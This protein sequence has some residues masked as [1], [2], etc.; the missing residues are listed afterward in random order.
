MVVLLHLE[1]FREIFNASKSGTLLESPLPK[2][3]IAIFKNLKKG[4]GNSFSKR[5][6][7]DGN[8]P[9]VVP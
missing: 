9:P 5:G 7:Y 6:G 8:V 3:G 4:D 1:A 2:G